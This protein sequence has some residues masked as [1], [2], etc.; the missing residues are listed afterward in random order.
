MKLTRRTV[1]AASVA[2]LGSPLVTPAAKASPD[3]PTK[4]PIRLIAT[5]PPGGTAD[6]ISRILAPKLSAALGTQV[7][8]DNK[9]GAG[10]TIG[11]DLAAKS[12]N[13]GYTLLMATG[14]THSVGPYLQKLPYDPARDFTPVTYVGYATNILLVSP[15]LGV[16]NVR[17][18]IAYAKQEPGRLTYATSGIGSVAHL[19]AEM[20]ASM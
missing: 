3:W 7:V 10:G 1:L 12:P 15:K 13:D 4:A 18:L 5:F 20:F 8:V 17:E 19:T 6:T 2:T 9:P 16:S 14:S 11:S